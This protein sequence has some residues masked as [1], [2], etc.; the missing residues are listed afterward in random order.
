MQFILYICLTVLNF[1]QALAL[2][3]LKGNELFVS[4]SIIYVNIGLLIPLV[5]YS[6]SNIFQKRYA[7]AES[8]N[9][10]QE[11]FNK[12]KKIS[13][14]SS[15]I[16]FIPGFL[17]IEYMFQGIFEYT[18]L[19][20]ILLTSVALV[21]VELSAAKLRVDRDHKKLV[22][23]FWW[24]IIC[25]H[26]LRFPVIL[27][28]CE[29]QLELILIIF[30]SHLPTAIKYTDKDFLITKVSLFDGLITKNF[31]MFI[32]SFFGVLIT[33]F[34]KIV[35]VDLLDPLLLASLFV[36]SKF[37]NAITVFFTKTYGLYLQGTVYNDVKDL[38]EEH[39]KK[40]FRILYFKNIKYSIFSAIFIYIMSLISLKFLDYFEF[41]SLTSYYP[42][43]LFATSIS[44]F[45]FSLNF[46]ASY[47]LTSQELFSQYAIINVSSALIAMIFTHVFFED[48]INLFLLILFIVVPAYINYTV[49]NVWVA[50]TF[51]IFYFIYIG[52][53][54]LLLISLIL[55][56]DY[57]G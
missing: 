19:I 7:F 42:L 5:S 32:A 45:V 24:R 28:V 16:F 1:L 49:I 8:A 21:S 52:V 47:Q 54:H 17:I 20:L 51:D 46:T 11:I 40:Y 6:I 10:K 13:L 33:F 12:C 34:D 3:Y 27:L 15:L 29:T 9:D 50:A 44:A 53:V 48:N 22:E 57:Y 30:I 56:A 2:P 55:I 18:E 36:C 41:F 39:K 31:T 38:T 35:L 26:F 14:L 43:I 23:L 37:S 25:E 4:Y